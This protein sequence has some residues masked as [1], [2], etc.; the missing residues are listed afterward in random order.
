[1]KIVREHINEIKQNIEG[2]GLGRIG[3]GHDEIMRKLQYFYKHY[4][5]YYHRLHNDNHGKRIA[6]M[7][8]NDVK[9][10]IVY[11]VELSILETL[12]YFK[13]N[14]SIFYSVY[15]KKLW[16]WKDYNFIIEHI[17]KTNTTLLYI[18]KNVFNEKN[19]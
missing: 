4:I 10:I 13:E 1:M 14:E 2:S 15:N 16:I 12:L 18:N 11:G 19:I 17:S 5:D 3:V 9:D 7:L 8:G 6:K